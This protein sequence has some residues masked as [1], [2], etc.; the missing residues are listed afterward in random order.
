MKAL[1]KHLIIE[2][3]DCDPDVL[4]DTD[5]CQAHLLKAVELSGATTIQPFF[6]KFSPHGVSGIVVIA[7]SHFSV[8]TWPEYGYCAIDIFT[9]GDDIDSEPA[10]RYL[11]EKFQADHYSVME[12]KR[13]LL[14]L[15]HSEVKHKP[16]MEYT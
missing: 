8:H 2:F 1:G 15:P 9:C 14:N 11:K 13:G 12:I 10:V 7:E 16:E 3:H 6:H 4:N 5:T